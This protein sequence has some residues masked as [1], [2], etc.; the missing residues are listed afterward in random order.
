MIKQHFIIELLQHNDVHYKAVCKPTSSWALMEMTRS[1][2]NL[3]LET[4]AQIYIEDSP[5][6]SGRVSISDSG[7]LNR[8]EEHSNHNHGV[9][10]RAV[11]E[12][13]E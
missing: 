5:P 10:L 2:P 6:V 8:H 4:G 3:E 11:C 12:I 13:I 1:I 9:V 7:C